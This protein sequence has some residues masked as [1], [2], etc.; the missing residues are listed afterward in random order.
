VLGGSV[1]WRGAVV[2]AVNRVAAKAI[3]KS[4]V[5]GEVYS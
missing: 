1:A 4:L 3:E 5:I 2:Q